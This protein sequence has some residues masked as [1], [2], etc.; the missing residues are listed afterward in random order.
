[1]LPTLYVMDARLSSLNIDRIIAGLDRN[2][3][4]LPHK[5]LR[6]LAN[7]AVRRG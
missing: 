2:R 4:A 7:G 6:F 1:V 3:N 5:D